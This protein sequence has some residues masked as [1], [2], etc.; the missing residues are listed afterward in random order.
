[1]VRGC[2]ETKAVGIRVV[3]LRRRRAGAGLALVTAIALGGCTN[4]DLDANAGWFSKPF[5]IA[6]RKGGF[7]FN[8]FKDAQQERPIT[9]ADLVDA[10]GACPASVV[11]GS[12]GPAQGNVD[13]APAAP[14]APLPDS[15]LGGGIGLGMSEC[16]V[17]RRAGAATNVTIGT[18]PRGERSVVLTYRSGPRPGI[19]RFT[20]GRLVEIERVEEPPAEAPKK[21]GKPTRQAKKN[22]TI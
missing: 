4:I 21:K 19:Y 11:T 18:T 1:M 16:D 5:D 10:G 12:S 22:D 9:A 8:E 13:G 14:A 20:A 17:V 7:T 3:E 2:G 6:G 15:L